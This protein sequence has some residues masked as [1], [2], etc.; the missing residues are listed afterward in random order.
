[1]VAS[2]FRW[3]D[4]D[5]QRLDS[6]IRDLVRSLHF[7]EIITIMSCEGHIRTSPIYV[8]VLPWPWIIIAA[9]PKQMTDLT[10]RLDSWNRL[11]PAKKWI[12]SVQR[13][14]GSFTPDY[15]RY[16]I[17]TNFPGTSVRTLCPEEENLGLS[18]NILA[19]LQKQ[20]PDLAHFLTEPS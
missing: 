5:Y 18:G 16:M 6:G 19:E 7:S 13:I 1:M 12:L 2:I 4:K 8:G 20:S 17:K 14:H 3:S 11:N 10:Q 9:E 15:V